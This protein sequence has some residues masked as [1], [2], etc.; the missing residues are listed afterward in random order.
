MAEQG[1][2]VG[3]M[4]GHLSPEP[5]EEGRHRAHDN[6]Q[7]E[8]VA[9][10]DLKFD[11]ME[12]FVDDSSDRNPLLRADG[13]REILEAR[14]ETGMDIPSAYVDYFETTPLTTHDLR[15]RQWSRD[16]LMHLMAVLPEVGIR[17]MC[18]P[19][20]DKSNIWHPSNEDELIRVVLR[21]IR[22]YDNDI[23]ILFKTDLA[24]GRAAGFINRLPPWC[25]GIDYDMGRSAFCELDPAKELQFFGNRVWHV[26]IKDCIPRL[27]K[28][29]LGKGEVDF[30]NVFQLLSHHGYKGDFV[31]HVHRYGL[32]DLDVAWNNA[33]TARKWIRQYLT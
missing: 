25:C 24:P 19:L 21:A 28:V 16:L 22:R 29:A 8:I 31:V 20:V 32:G 3:V 33:R 9:A 18:I 13:R 17:R 6:W 15:A 7:K 27:G 26:R 12:W 1:N 30:D 10:A 23:Q 2:R 11:F 4:L 14:R 5:P